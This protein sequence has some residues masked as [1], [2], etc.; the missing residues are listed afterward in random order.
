MLSNFQG[1][2]VSSKVT[3]LVHSFFVL[4]FYSFTHE[5]HRERQR[6]RQRE[7][8]AP[9]REPNTRLNSG[10]PGSRPG[11]KAVWATHVPH[12]VH[13]LTGSSLQPIAQF[14]L[15]V[16]TSGD[17]KHA[18]SWCC[19]LFHYWVALMVN[20]V[21]PHMYQA[22]TCLH[23]WKSHLP[24]LAAWNRTGGCKRYLGYGLRKIWFY[25]YLPPPSHVTLNQVTSAICASVSSSV[26]QEHKYA[27]RLVFGRRKKT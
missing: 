21:F 2:K 1:H 17:K 8:Q 25:S 20:T 12:L 5:R 7:K 27:W 3:I 14:S 4:R 24:S 16:N 9:C 11:P 22:A 23:L 19:C 6:H 13:F 15:S 18:T 26:Q 10:T